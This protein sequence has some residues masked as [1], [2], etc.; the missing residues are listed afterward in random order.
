MPD[1]ETT[2]L[3]SDQE[4]GGPKPPS[5]PRRLLWFAAIW[6]AGILTLGAISFGIKALVK[7]PF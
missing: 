1:I 6:L 3:P 7:L 5:W 4:R 2:E